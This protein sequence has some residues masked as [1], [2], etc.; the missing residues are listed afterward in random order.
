MI[1]RTQREFSR[2]GKE[3]PRHSSTTTRN[4]TANL[5]NETWMDWGFSLPP[6]FT[7]RK[8]VRVG[9]QSEKRYGN[10]SLCTLNR[11]GVKTA[12]LPG[13]FARRNRD[14]GAVCS[15]RNLSRRESAEVTGNAW[16]LLT[17]GLVNVAAPPCPSACTLHVPVPEIQLK[18]RLMQHSPTSTT[19]YC[20]LPPGPAPRLATCSLTE[21]MVLI[22]APDSASTIQ[23][24]A[25]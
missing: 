25:P 7:A 8:P 14:S 13:G 1:Y 23:V 9:A 2:L 22:T 21:A 10:Y 12:T 18:H 4:I 5:P 16:Q 11:A 24:F 20:V 15:F 17:S 6:K 19:V 3:E